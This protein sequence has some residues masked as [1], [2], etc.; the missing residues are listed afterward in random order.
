M[1]VLSITKVPMDVRHLTVWSSQLK[2]C[3]R[4]PYPPAVFT[5][6]GHGPRPRPVDTDSVYRA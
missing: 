3:I 4:Y 1:R 6:R 2:F 5:G